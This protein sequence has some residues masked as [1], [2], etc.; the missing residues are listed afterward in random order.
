[1]NKINT[2]K[3]ALTTTQSEIIIKKTTALRILAVIISLILGGASVFYLHMEYF[4]ANPIGLFYYS[5]N[6]Y[7]ILGFALNDLFMIAANTLIVFCILGILWG[8]V[9]R[10]NRIM[11]AAVSALTS[12]ASACVLYNHCLSRGLIESVGIDKSLLI[13]RVE[14]VIYGL[15]VFSAAWLIGLLIL[16]KLKKREAV[17]T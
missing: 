5:F 13:F 15:L 6:F 11:L 1:M 9:G 10:L 7:G 14:H 4:L 12:I 16:K 17:N 3:K 2:D 8:I